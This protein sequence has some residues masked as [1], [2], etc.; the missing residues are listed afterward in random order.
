MMVLPETINLFPYVSSVCGERVEYQSV[1]KKYLELCSPAKLNR[2]QV[3]CLNDPLYDNVIKRIFDYIKDHPSVLYKIFACSGKEFTAEDACAIPSFGIVGALIPLVIQIAQNGGVLDP[4]T[5]MIVYPAG[6]SA[7]SPSIGPILIGAAI[8][9]SIILATNMT[10]NIIKINRDQ[11]TRVWT[12]T[13]KQWMMTDSELSVLKDDDVLRDFLCPITRDI[14]TCPVRAPNYLTYDRKAI[15]E[16]LDNGKV[17]PRCSQLFSKDD[18]VFDHSHANTI[19]I[20]IKE[21]TTAIFDDGK[22]LKLPHVHYFCSSY[23]K[24][25]NMVVSEL[26]NNTQGLAEIVKRSS[27]FSDKMIETKPIDE[28]T[29]LI[30]L[31]KEHFKGIADEFKTVSRKS[32]KVAVCTNNWFEKIGI[33]LF[34]WAGVRPRMEFVEVLPDL[35]PNIS[36][37]RDKRLGISSTPI[38]Y[39]QR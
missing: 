7:V 27:D 30:G 34:G 5:E 31:E 9:A 28:A 22:V 37:E 10:I 25:R 23:D 19:C 13:R 24:K 17:P 39:E 6:I 18:L 12:E 38:P 4:I 26:R 20:R 33:S 36:N 29:R 35:F 1:R 16:M 21:I 32:V 15:E 8:G 3:K 2:R 11:A 14:P